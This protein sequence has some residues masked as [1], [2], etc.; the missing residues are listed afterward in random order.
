MKF[1]KLFE[2][3]IIESKQ[4]GILYHSTHIQQALSIISENSIDGSYFGNVD[5]EKMG[6][7][8]TRNKNFIY[9]RRCVQF[10]INGDKISN[11]YKII[12]YDYWLGNYNVSDN[13]QTQDEFEE[14]IITP[15]GKIKNF[16]DYL[17]CVNIL[18]YDENEIFDE[19]LKKLT[20]L[21]DR[22]NIPFKIKTI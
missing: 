7:S 10:V 4:V 1:I 2:D 14:I 21:L 8:T 5:S 13:P 17:L 3:Y 15:K 11:N 16:N 12:Q 6:L 19:F 20:N 22:K 18:I 9:D